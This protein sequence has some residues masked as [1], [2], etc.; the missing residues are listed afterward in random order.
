MTWKPLNSTPLTNAMM[1]AC[2]D[3]RALKARTGVVYFNPALERKAATHAVVTRCPTCL[4]IYE[5]RQTRKERM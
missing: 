4:P 3:F 5:A 2:E 1:E